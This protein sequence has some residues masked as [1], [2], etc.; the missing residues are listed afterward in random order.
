MNQEIITFLKA[1]LECS[2]FRAPTD[3]GL[4]YE[5]ILEVG[6]RGGW[7][8]GEIGDALQY[9][10]TQFFGSKR[11]L[12]DSNTVASWVF[13]SREDPE[14][15]NFDAFDF[16]V[17]ELNA[18]ARADGAAN[19]RLERSLVVERAVAKGISRRD[20][21]VAITYQSMGNMLTEKD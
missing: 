1:A 5:E 12:P 14:Y 3:P 6:K 18:R 16:V 13:L 2:V 4:S 17:S 21:E 8:H 7:Q 9:A 19:A 10:T 11:L 20:I 15:R